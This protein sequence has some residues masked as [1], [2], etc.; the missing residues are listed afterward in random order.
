[1]HTMPKEGWFLEG[2]CLASL[3][4]LLLRTLR[5]VVVISKARV[6]ELVVCILC[7]RG[8]VASTIDTTI[9]CIYAYN[10]HSLYILS[11]VVL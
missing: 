11:L 5:A 1:M 3:L 4:D 10:V 7:I 9:L 6:Y 8:L 2:G